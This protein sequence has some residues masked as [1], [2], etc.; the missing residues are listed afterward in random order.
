MEKRL[1]EQKGFILEKDKEDDKV[2]QMLQDQEK[3]AS[4][5][6]PMRSSRNAPQ[7]VQTQKLQKQEQSTDHAVDI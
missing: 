1:H 2:F 3:K 5:S 6:P 7:V 4:L